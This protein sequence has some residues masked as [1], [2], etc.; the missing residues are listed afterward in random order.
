MESENIH[1]GE[2]VRTKLVINNENGDKWNLRMESTR[3]QG[4]TAF[5]INSKTLDLEKAEAEKVEPE[6]TSYKI[7]LSRSDIIVIS[8]LCRFTLPY[9]LG[10]D[11]L[12]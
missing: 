9:L 10:W 3:A 11:V 4:K 12:D 6:V 1:G 2:T 8:E 5:S 7:P